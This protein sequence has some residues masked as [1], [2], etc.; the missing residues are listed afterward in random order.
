M[1]LKEHLIELRNRLFISLIALFVT[2]VAGFFLYNPVMEI[3][4]EP[5]ADAGGQANFAS[6]VSP[7]DMLIK[8]SVFLG[9]IMSAPVW[10]YQLWAFIVPGLHKKEKWTTVG[11]ISA[12]L[13]LFLGGI[14]LGFWA[15]PYALIFFVGLTP[16]GAV[17]YV[18]APEYLD[19][20]LRLFLAFGI[21]F[22]LP[23][24]VVGLNMIGILPGKLILKNWRITVFLICLV[25]AMAAPGGD[26]LTMFVLAGPLLLLF[27]AA[28]GFCLYNDKRRAKRAAERDK[29]NEENANNAS[30]LPD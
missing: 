14:V 18:T 25:A 6:A 13:P 19:F 23:V 4:M 27:V 20:V 3:I 9:L 26:A 22:L 11:F 29:E 17:N 28:T 5:L 21:A 15:L 16:G 10:L 1:S 24:L 30:P 2:T 12:A 8:V 7:L